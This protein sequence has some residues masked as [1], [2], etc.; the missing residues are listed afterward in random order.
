MATGSVAQQG[1]DL[2]LQLGVGGIFAFII[3]KEVLTIV[4][5]NKRNGG[6][7]RATTP[8]MFAILRDTQTLVR[9]LH[10]WHD[11][12]DEDHVFV[13]YVRKSLEHQ[14]ENLAGAVESMSRAAQ[15]QTD[16]IESAF[17]SMLDEIKGML[18]E[19]KALRAQGRRSG[20]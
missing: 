15:R 14:I 16:I 10:K 8:D 20:D 2:L 17:E 11:A 6:P 3:I 18:A 7:S 19:L 13:W 5:K 4:F 1:G 9:E 12:K